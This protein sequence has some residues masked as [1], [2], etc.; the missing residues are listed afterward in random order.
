MSEKNQPPQRPIPTPPTP[1]V[2]IDKGNSM[3]TYQTPPPPPPPPPA[4]KD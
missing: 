1:G 2:T 3:P 4:K